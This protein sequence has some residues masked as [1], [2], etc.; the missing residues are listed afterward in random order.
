M[1]LYSS[2]D[3]S[4]YYDEPVQ[5]PKKEVQPHKKQINSNEVPSIPE[6]KRKSLYE[7][8]KKVMTDKEKSGVDFRNLYR[9][10]QMIAVQGPNG[11]YRTTKGRIAE[12]VAEDLM[13]VY[14]EDAYKDANENWLVDFVTAVD[15]IYPL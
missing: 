12:I 3:P 7:E 1:A 6:T 5:K 9:V 4:E 14:M 11:Q 10:G 8:A 15:K 13:Y 2:F